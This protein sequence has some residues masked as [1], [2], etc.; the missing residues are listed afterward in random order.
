M[1]FQKKFNL[2]SHNYSTKNSMYSFKEPWF[3]LKITKFTI[4]SRG[5]RLR[6]LR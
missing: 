2:I 4:W 1:K 5:P 6:N 3:S